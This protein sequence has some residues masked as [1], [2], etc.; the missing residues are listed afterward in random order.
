M[1]TEDEKDVWK[2]AYAASHVAYWSER[3]RPGRTKSECSET[4][5][6]RAERATSAFRELKAGG[7]LPWTEAE[8]EK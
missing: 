1:M 6:N 3:N 2:A 7:F 4:A 5:R 8:G